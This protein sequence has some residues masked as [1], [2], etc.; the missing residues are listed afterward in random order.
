MIAWRSNCRIL[1]RFALSCLLSLACASAQTG[2][3]QP[4]NFVLLKDAAEA[5]AAGDLHKAETELNTVLVTNPS[6]YRATNLLGVVRAQ[7]HRE[8]EAEQLFKQA[9]QEKP[10]FASAHVDLGLLYLQINR[11][12]DAVPEF[13]EALR[14]DPGRSDALSALLGF[15]RTQARDALRNGD[16]EKALAVLIQAHKMAPQDADITFEFGIVALRMSLLPDAVQA[17]Q[18]VLNV[19]K[20][21]PSAIYGLGRAQMELRKYQEAK[22]LFEH[23]AQLRP[24]DASGHYALGFALQALQQMADARHQFELS[25]EL[26]PVQTESYFQI[27]LIEL[28]ANNLESAASQFSRVLEHDSKHAGALTGMGR[29]EFERKQ[30]Q[31]AAELLQRAIASD[32]SLREGHYYLGLSYARLGQKDD[33]EKEL[34]IASQLE[35]EEVE[36]RRMVIKILDSNDPDAK[37]LLDENK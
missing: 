3:P 16:L 8:A 14:I 28:E 13:K 36:K 5:I 29:V 2:A 30:Y 7:Q 33:S 1:L 35:H 26:Q 32:S 18:E 34:Q 17:F 27:G 20:N 24:Q 15:W 21:D 22:E 6:E 9:I 23:Y 25:I 12:D 19:R 4:G 10:D 37:Q 11:R 31:K